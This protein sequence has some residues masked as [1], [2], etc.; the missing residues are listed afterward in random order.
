MLPLPLD[1][2]IVLEEDEFRGTVS[3]TLPLS[4]FAV[5]LYWVG[6]GGRTSVMLPLLLFT[7]TWRGTLVKT[8][9]MSPLPV[10]AEIVAVAM[11]D[12][13]MLPL[14]VFAVIVVDVTPS[15][16]MSPSPD[17]AESVAD[18]TAFT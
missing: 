2:A 4:V 11:A 8:I 18:L 16:W 17:E 12:P 14:S 6:P 10:E 7:R 15:A 9:W 3:L 1:A 13:S 5:T